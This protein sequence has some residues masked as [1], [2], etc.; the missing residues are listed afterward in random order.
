MSSLFR[1]ENFVWLGL[2]LAFPILMLS[3]HLASLFFLDYAIT[4]VELLKFT[5]ISMM[6]FALIHYLFVERRD[7]SLEWRRARSHVISNERRKKSNAVLAC[8]FAIAT[9][10][11]VIWV[12]CASVLFGPELSVAH[13][14]ALP[15]FFF[16][17]F[18]SVGMLSGGMSSNA[19]R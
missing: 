16:T 1:R 11:G 13:V 9:G 14:Y 2:A 8:S 17:L 4:G 7:F 12:F 6:L 18:V 15:A 3:V 10:L 19:S 5:S